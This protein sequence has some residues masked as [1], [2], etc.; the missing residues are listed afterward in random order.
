MALPKAE[1]R[2][3]SALLVVCVTLL[4]SSFAAR[5]RAA[6]WVELHV[7][8]DDLKVEIDANGKAIVEHRMVLLVNGG[9]LKEL[10]LRGV[11]ADAELEPNGWVAPEKDAAS[12]PPESP[13]PLTFT[14]LEAKVADGAAPR[15]DVVVGLDGSAGI[16]R[17]RWIA[18]VRYH[19]DLR[20]TG[21]LTEDGASAL[22]RWSGAVWD[23]GLDT[24]K[25]TFVLPRAPT[26]PRV[27][28]DGGDVDDADDE[29][30]SS[31]ATLT[32]RPT[33]D[34][35][36]LVRPYASKGQRVVWSLRADKRAFAMGAP[37][38]EA[39]APLAAAPPRVDP[40]PAAFGNVR[41]GILFGVI[42]ALFLALASVVAGHASY[43]KRVAE[44]RGQTAQPLV[45]LPIFVRAVLAAFAWL[46]GVGLGLAL[47]APLAG[48]LVASLF[49]PLVWHRTARQKTTMRPPGQWLAVTRREALGVGAAI[50]PSS[51]FDLGRARGKL[52]FTALALV[53]GAGVY[54]V[55]TRSSYAAVLLALDALPLTALFLSGVR[56]RLLPDLAVA[57]AQLLD[58]VARRVESKSKRAVRVV[59]KIRVP[60]GQADADEVR[61]VF[62][63]RDPVRGFKGLEIGTSPIAGPGGVLLLPEILV[64]CEEGSPAARALRDAPGYGRLSRGRRADECVLAVSPKIPTAR[65]TADLALALLD[66]LAARAVDRA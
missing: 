55:S 42:G 26:E 33:E 62:L 59:P 43:A 45:P 61:V 15:T 12:G 10:T 2:L 27:A 24:T 8:R 17:G 51:A 40:L 34:V 6:G 53:V 56:R 65:T 38:R 35:L 47:D 32:R 48:A 52:A 21:A 31:L 7:A 14:K 54:L 3:F 39:R 37:A 25:A 20:A 66:R 49:V 22:L 4:V 1:R 58:K 16:P 57:P 19:T 29:G 30:A 41:Q 46:S 13:L 11:D 63:P 28:S 23:D 9:S 50:G 64:R 18:V 5:A 36:D 60:R 44:E